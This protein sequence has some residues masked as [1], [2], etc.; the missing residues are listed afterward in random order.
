M[1]KVAK[2]KK[3]LQEEADLMLS[4]SNGLLLSIKRYNERQMNIELNIIKSCLSNI[5][6]YS[7]QIEK[8]EKRNKILINNSTK[9]LDKRR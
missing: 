9:K 5:E 8:E 6:D 4:A 7:D 2:L 3:L 1:N